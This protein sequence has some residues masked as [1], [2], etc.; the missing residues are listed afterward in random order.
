MRSVSTFGKLYAPVE[1]MRRVNNL[2]E[3]IIDLDNIALAHHKAKLGKK[4]YSEVQLVE[5]N[6]DYYLSQVHEILKTKTFTTSKYVTKTIY[7]PKERVIYKLPYYPD[8]IV[9]HAVMNII[10]PIWDRVFID[11]CYSAIP[12]KGLHA[13]FLRLRKFLRDESNTRYCLKFDI[14][15]YYPSMNHDILLSLVER[16]IKCKDT[17]WLLED[18][19]RSPGGGNNVPI[20]NYLSQYFA[21]IYLNW[22]D[23]WLKEEK[24]VK[25]YVR[26]S[27][28]GVILHEDKGFLQSLLYEMVDYLDTNLKLKLNPKTQIFMVDKRGVDFLGYRSFRNYTLLRKSSAKRFKSKLKYI[29]H[30]YNSLDPTYV[31]SA[32]MSYAGWLKYCDSY[33]LRKSFVYKDSILSITDSASGRLGIEN[34]VRSAMNEDYNRFSQFSVEKQVLSG[35][36]INLTNILDKEILITDFRVSKSKFNERNYITIQF[37]DG[38]VTFVTFTGSEVLINQLEKYK[39][40]VPFYTTIVKKG[41][42]FTLT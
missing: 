4:H 35:D 13:G 16:K 41:R 37:I 21:N 26:Y 36:K 38:G 8:R 18:V 39:S 5:S 1:I 15:K 34:P 17:L 23:H 11:D 6:L 14:K 7:E 40:K 30:N 20:G 28:D 25:Y 27:D 33:N 22:F 9:H 42:Y 31:I 12:K 19:I 2:F 29:E 10:Q 24:G 3:Q 32:I